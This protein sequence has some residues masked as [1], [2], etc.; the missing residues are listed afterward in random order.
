MTKKIGQLRGQHPPQ[1]LQGILW[2]CSVDKLDLWKDRVYIIHQILM[3]GSFKEIRWLYTVYSDNLINDIFANRPMKV[4]TKTG[5]N[6]VKNYILNLSGQDI[7]P[8]KYVNAFYGP[9]RR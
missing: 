1:R 3:Y 8:D 5:F 6:Y 9:S 2:S 7:S 4:Y